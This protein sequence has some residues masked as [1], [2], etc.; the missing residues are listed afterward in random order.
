L[1]SAL[2]FRPYLASNSSS[3]IASSNVL[4]QSRPMLNTIGLE[5]LPILRLH[6]TGGDRGLAAHADQRQLVALLL[7]LVEASVLAEYV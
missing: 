7:G 3:K 5:T 6:I 2:G 4:E 1:I